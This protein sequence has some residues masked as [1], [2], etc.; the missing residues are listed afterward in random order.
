VDDSGDGSVANTLRASFPDIQWVLHEQN[1]GFGPSASESVLSCQADIVVLLN[2]D[3][4]LL[5]DPAP[6][7]QQLFRDPALFAV[8]FRSQREDGAFREGAKR[9]V[10]PMGF[11]RILHGER[12]QLP[13]VNGLHPSAYAVGGHAAYRKEFFAAL[14]GFDPLFEPF[15]WEDVD[16][17]ARALRRGWASAYCPECRVMHGEDGAIRTRHSAALIR[18][19]TMRNRLLFAWR[20]LPAH[21]K[22]LH[23][24]SLLYHLTAS[25]L[26]SGP[27][28]LRAFLSA[29]RRW[30]SA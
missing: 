3:V 7:L 12:D 22:P 27:A 8:T 16:I 23:T 17:C 5:S 14:D 13:P 21:L 9:L 25:V 28:F 19:L 29:R 18:E 1:Q 15:Y 6:Q 2:D 20:H 4:L 10:W 30:R 11:P 24:L 26:L